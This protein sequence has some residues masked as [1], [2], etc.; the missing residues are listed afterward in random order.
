MQSER[1]LV[2]LISLCSFNV[3]IAEFFMTLF[4][5]GGNKQGLSIC[6]KLQHI[7]IKLAL[8]TFFCLS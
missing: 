6:I 5:S 2:D 4:I 8:C 1:S 7:H 3:P